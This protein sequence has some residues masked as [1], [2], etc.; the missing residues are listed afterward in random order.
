MFVLEYK[1]RDSAGDLYTP[2]GSKHTIIIKDLKTLRGIKW[3]LNNWYNVPH[4]VE[5]INIYVCS[6]VSDTS[7]YKLLEVLEWNK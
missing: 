3:R 2:A 6:K 4:D 5:E 1:V 7:T